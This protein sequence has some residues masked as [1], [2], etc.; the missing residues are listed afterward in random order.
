MNF[1]NANLVLFV[2]VFSTKIGV[3]HFGLFL[4]CG[5]STKVFSAKSYIASFRESFIPRK[6]PTTR[7]LYNFII[8]LNG[9]MQSTT[10]FLRN[11]NKF[12]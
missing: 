6:F 8:C 5:E 4:V 2:K 12:L 1:A 7:Q 10:I 11:S 3:A 9:V